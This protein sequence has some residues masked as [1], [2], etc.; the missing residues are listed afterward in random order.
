MNKHIEDRIFDY[1]KKIRQTWVIRLENLATGMHSKPEIVCR[2]GLLKTSEEQDA[3][4][5]FLSICSPSRM[6][7]IAEII[8]AFRVHDYYRKTDELLEK[9]DNMR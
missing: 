3:A 6:E 4:I 7:V 9:L 5:E 8:H 1:A 2:T